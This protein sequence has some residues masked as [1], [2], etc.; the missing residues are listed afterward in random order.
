[1]SEYARL[2]K[3]ERTWREDERLLAQYI[4]RS[5][6]GRKLSDLSRTDIERLHATIGEEHGHYAANHLTRLLR[7]MLNRALDWGMLRG[8]NPAQRM[9]LFREQKRERYLSPDELQ[10]VNKAL[11][12]EPDW[13]WRAYSPLAFML[14][15]RK[16][17]LLAMRWPDVDLLARTWRTPE[18][19]AG[20]SHLLPVPSPASAILEALPSRGKSEWVFPGQ[21]ASGHILEPAKA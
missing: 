12:E 13:R 7:H 19:K 9:K 11:L 17:V 16:S 15:T 10:K 4:P 3:R 21:S 14:G 8:V 6:N 2:H 18:T 1:M 5:W 20:N